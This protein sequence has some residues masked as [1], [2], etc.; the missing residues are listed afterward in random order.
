[1]F[2]PMI[3]N[4]FT[5]CTVLVCLVC[6]PFVVFVYQIAQW[7]AAN[8]CVVPE[9]SASSHTEAVLDLVRSCPFF[10]ESSKD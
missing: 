5:I 3:I 1:M 10:V 8:E 9:T 6:V 2:P 7:C 4:W